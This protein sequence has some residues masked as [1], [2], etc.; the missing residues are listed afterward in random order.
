[1]DLLLFLA[2]EPEADESGIA[3]DGSHVVLPTVP[4][5]PQGALDEQVGEARGDRGAAAAGAA[6]RLEAR[7]C[8]DAAAVG[9]VDAFE[10][11]RQWHVVGAMQELVE[12]L[13]GGALGLPGRGRDLC[14]LVVLPSAV[15]G[16]QV[17]FVGNEHVAA[18]LG[19]VDAVPYDA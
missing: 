1:M 5:D 6:A 13:E 11:E 2:G 12:L 10:V 18:V 16:E 8:L 19:G 17:V 15:V 14:V 3:V 9:Q 4:V 7:D